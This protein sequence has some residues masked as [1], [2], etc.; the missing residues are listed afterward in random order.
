M[1]TDEE[2]NVNRDTVLLEVARLIWRQQISINEL[3]EVLGVDLESQR[4][5]T[6]EVVAQLAGVFTG[7]THSPEER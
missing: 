3:Y 5:D 7:W 6:E 1:S 2:Q 4:C